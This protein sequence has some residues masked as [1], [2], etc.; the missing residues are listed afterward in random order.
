MF[1]ALPSEIAANEIRDTVISFV[2]MSALVNSWKK[3]IAKKQ[4]YKMDLF[5]W[6]APVNLLSSWRE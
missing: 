5:K 6:N 1:R 3:I 2:F 4:S